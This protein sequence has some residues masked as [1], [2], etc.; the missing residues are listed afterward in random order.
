MKKSDQ[1]LKHAMIDAGIDTWAELA[2][3]LHITETTLRNRRRHPSL[4][5]LYDIDVLADTLKK[6]AAEVVDIVGMW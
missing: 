6:P 3:K 2:R 4:W 5:N 1:R